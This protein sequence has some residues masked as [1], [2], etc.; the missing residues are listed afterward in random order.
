MSRAVVL[1]RSEA[2][3]RKVAQ[4]AANV[5]PGSSVEFKAPRRSPDQ[6]ALMWSLLGEVSRQV[7]WY[8]QHLTSEDWKDVFTASLRRA[9]VVPG[10][11]PG[12][13]VPLGMRTSDMTKQEMTDLIE[14]ILAFCAE[15]GVV[16][17]EVAA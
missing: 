4:W 6:N 3:R 8:G 11:D 1:I 10:I 15:R 2:D 5:P 17:G 13:F 9:R 7:E 12:S 14:L 16:T